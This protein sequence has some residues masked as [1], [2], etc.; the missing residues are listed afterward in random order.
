MNHNNQ[1]IDSAAAGEILRA[2][3]MPGVEA[4]EHD[5]FA[6]LIAAMVD[7]S[8][9][10]DDLGRME[11]TFMQHVANCALCHAEFED[12]LAVQRAE[13]AGE[14]SAPPPPLP[15]AWARVRAALA[16]TPA[17]AMPSVWE[18]IEEGIQT[19]VASLTFTMQA[20]RLMLTNLP[21]RLQPFYE[22]QPA[23]AGL[24]M[25][26]L[27]QGQMEIPQLLFP[28]REE[29]VRV[30]LVPGAVS[31][32]AG[33]LLVQIEEWGE[34]LPRPQVRVS[35]LDDN[36]YPLE[37]LYTDADGAAIFKELI[38]GHYIILIDLGRSYKCPFH[39]T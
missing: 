20:G 35:L 30:R 9:A 4:D 36:G 14:L 17:R 28:L 16:N 13:A 1:N 31:E 15:S 18:Q 34:G 24:R 25:R 22:L 19:L 11:P 12:L 29:G 39:V 5:H 21:A 27:E 7:R 32:A 38:V 37:R 10:G 6:D 26:S 8:L 2:V 3:Y 23:P 33:T